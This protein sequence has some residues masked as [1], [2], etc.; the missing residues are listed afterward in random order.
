[1]SV[2]S[3]STVIPAGIIKLSRT[4]VPAR[5][6]L[7]F[8][9][10]LSPSVNDPDDRYVIDKTGAFVSSESAVLLPVLASSV[11]ITR[12]LPET[13]PPLSTISCIIE[14]RGGWR[15]EEHTSELQSR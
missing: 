6:L 1:M 15:S 5:V 11:I 2:V 3:I 8:T 14:D 13:Q 9:P 7:P 4:I 10:V 12:E